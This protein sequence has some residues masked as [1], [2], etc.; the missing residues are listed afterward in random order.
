MTA[1][2]PP[3]ASVAPADMQIKLADDDA[4]DRELLL[5]L[6]RDGRFH[7]WTQ[8]RRT[9]R[10]ER[11]VVPFIDPWRHPPMAFPAVRTPSLP[12]W[13]FGILLQRFRKRRRLSESGA[14]RVVQLSLEML[15][16]LPE[17]LVFAAQSLAVALRFLGALAPVGVIRSTIRVVRCGR[18][19]HAE[20]M[21]EFLAPYKTR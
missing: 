9:L 7:D 10:G 6:R 4:R 14:P 21:P 5:V 11:H 19:R 8:A 18:I 20:V 16:L 3:T 15:D 13:T 2:H 12:A 1:L 17:T